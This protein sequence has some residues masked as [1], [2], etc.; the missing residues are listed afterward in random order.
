MSIKEIKEAL[1]GKNIYYYNGWNGSCD[2]FKIGHIVKSGTCA[3]VYPKK[4][5]PFGIVISINT[6]PTLVEKGEYIKPN[7]IEGC[8]YEDIWRLI[9]YTKQNGYENF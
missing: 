9:D 8:H 2:Y 4:G 6:I 7:E 5:E 1:M 3:I